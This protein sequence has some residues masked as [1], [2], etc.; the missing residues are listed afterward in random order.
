MAS[1][2]DDDLPPSLRDSISVNYGV[3]KRHD[4]VEQRQ[5]SKPAPQA[6]PKQEAASNPIDDL[7]GDLQAA[8]QRG[9]K[10]T[11]NINPHLKAEA[12]EP[13][14]TE[15]NSTAEDEKDAG[16][17]PPGL[18]DSKE[19]NYN[20]AP[21]ANQQKPDIISNRLKAELGVGALT[22]AYVNRRRSKEEARSGET[23]AQKYSNLPP[24]MRPVD[25]KSLQRYIN[26]QFSV[27]IP[28]EK[29]KE[30]TGMDIRTMKEV[31]E[32]RRIIEGS[33]AQRIPVK[34]D[35][36]GRTTTV[37]YRN[38]PGSAPIDI[39]GLGFKPSTFMSRLGSNIAEGAQSLAGG[40]MKYM[41]PVIGGM[42]AAPQL[43]RSATDFYQNKP[44]DPT[45]VAS[46]LGGLAMMSKNP[47]LGV[48]G[49]LAQVPY[50]VKHADEI[51]N[52][53]RMNDINPTAFPA[54]TVGAES[55]PLTEPSNKSLSQMLSE[56]NEKKRRESG[57]R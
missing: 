9:N 5:P 2:K 33:E 14:S 51:T 43:L 31:Q 3:G 49:G 21:V 36:D 28:L 23:N 25:A 27:E 34:K 22:G 47:A 29:L 32:A 45:Q 37:S 4:E 12:V 57:Y 52:A 35:V 53:L 1:T 56:S 42:V 18:K 20:A 7:I 50:A 6:K 10:G 40:A 41:Q 55:S 8:Q 17:L 19:M 26:S 44:V 30:L 54:G 24:E 39:S 38:I 16:N 13:I 48:V 11:Q 46:G 15:T